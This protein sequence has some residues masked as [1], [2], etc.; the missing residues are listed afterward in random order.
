MQSVKLTE[1]CLLACG[2]EYAAI[3][4]IVPA[5][6]PSAAYRKN[7]KRLLSRMRN[8]KYHTLTKKGVRLLIAAAL[9]AALAA[10]AAASTAFRE[11][12]LN[13]FEKY[14]TYEVADP[15]KAENL[16]GIVP[17]Y[18]PEGYECTKTEFPTKYGYSSYF[19]QDGDNWIGIDQLSIRS[20]IVFD[21]E[22]GT[23]KTVKRENGTERTISKTD[24]G[25]CV[26]ENDG[27][28]IYMVASNSITEEEAIKVFE[29]IKIL[30]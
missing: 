30:P 5:T 26:I 28:F 10:T 27:H 9:A 12:T 14:G 24:S 13:V 19:Y 2:T 1:A 11:Y 21:T 18:I 20:G 15:G 16:T 6:E 8:D 22:N 25:V 4:D 17:G 29:S 7:I 23:V 3:P